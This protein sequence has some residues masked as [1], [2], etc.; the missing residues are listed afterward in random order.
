[1]DSAMRWTSLTS[2]QHQS[3]SSKIWTFFFLSFDSK[4]Q[5]MEPTV[6]LFPHVL[7]TYSATTHL[8]A[9]T[10]YPGQDPGT[11]T[12]WTIS[13]HVSSWHSQKSRPRSGHG[14]GRWIIYTRPP[15]V[16]KQPAANDWVFNVFPTKLEDRCM[17]NIA[18]GDRNK[19]RRGCINPRRLLW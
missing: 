16:W 5:F 2:T 9:D 3:L 10:L 12:N 4:T 15:A 1:M 18:V 13:D 17:G 6:T 14:R 19:C 7:L 11:K 8:T